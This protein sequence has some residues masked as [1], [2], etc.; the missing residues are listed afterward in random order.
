MICLTGDVHHMRARSHRELVGSTEVE[1]AKKCVEIAE[2][3][4][5]KVTLHITGQT[6]EE[7]YESVIELLGYENLEIGGHT[8]S[9][10]KPRVLHYSF[11]LVSSSYY[12]PR[13]YQ[14]IDIKKTVNII[15]KTTGRRITSWR[16]HAY[17]SNEN[18]FKLLNRYGIRVVSDE[19]RRD[20]LFP[21]K[22]TNALVSL[23]I[24]VIPDHEHIFHGITTP[25]Y[26]SKES[27]SRPLQIAKSYAAR[28]LRINVWKRRNVYTDD[29]TSKSYAIGEWFE[30]VKKQVQNIDDKGGVATILAHPVC[31][32]VADKLQTFRELCDFLSEYDGIFARDALRTVKNDI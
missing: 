27:Y 32:Q 19:V 10:L 9:A 8:Y 20:A 2:A 21:R 22:T 3:H 17:A 14:S 6:F 28:A 1:I 25:E 23:P 24:N 15:N 29:F 4:D 13:F 18:T 7:E 5:V 12:G 11:G 16:T 26:V 31:M 30:I